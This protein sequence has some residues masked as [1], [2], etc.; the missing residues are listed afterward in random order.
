MFGEF[1]HLP[2]AALTPLQP[3]DRVGPHEIF[4]VLGTGAQ[5]TVYAV[6]HLGTGHRMALKVL[7]SDEVAMERRIVREAAALSRLRHPNIVRTHGMLDVGGRP[8]MLV[9][10]VEGGSLATRVPA[11]GLDAT[12]LRRL[13]RGLLG[14]VAH[15]HTM[16]LVHRDLKPENVLVRE[17][18]DRPLVCDFGLVRVLGLDRFAAYRTR[19]GAAMGT[20]GYMAPEQT[21]DAHHV[22][23]RADIF[24]LGALLYA[25]STGQPAFPGK[26]VVDVARRTWRGEYR[27][28][29]D[30]VPALDPAWVEGIRAALQPDPGARP[31]TVGALAALVLGADAAGID[32]TPPVPP[33]AGSPVDATFND[34]AR[35]DD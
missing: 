29:R 10:L 7:T 3:G 5:S 15:A 18:D 11:G 14:G 4:R 23:H 21:T 25:M 26:D 2:G 24:A 35:L 28:P 6:R 20:L 33:A 31:A 16:G 34:E 12:A 13:S 30:H 32:G 19:S 9:D 27:D 22:D 17:V 1:H 8:A